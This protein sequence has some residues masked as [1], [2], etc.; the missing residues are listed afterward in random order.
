MG[1][2]YVGSIALPAKDLTE[3]L[4][5]S[6]EGSPQVLC[7]PRS[8]LLRVCGMSTEHTLALATLWSHCARKRRVG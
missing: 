8:P 1:V 6:R 3:Q 2:G 4:A 5:C 7:A